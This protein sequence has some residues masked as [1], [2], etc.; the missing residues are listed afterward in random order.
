MRLRSRGVPALFPV[1]APLEG[2]ALPA[3]GQSRRRA[4]GDSTVFAPLELRE[5]RTAAGTRDAVLGARTAVP[6]LGKATA[7]G[8]VRTRRV[9][10][11][12][13]GRPTP[14]GGPT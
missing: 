5:D 6:W 14:A 10:W 11:P 9:G 12:R 3:A 2:S 7:A 1:A 13:G 8:P 4:G